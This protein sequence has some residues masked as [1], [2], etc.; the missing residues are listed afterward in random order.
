M[1]GGVQGKRLEH[2]G[3]DGRYNHRIRTVT[4]RAGYDTRNADIVRS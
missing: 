3:A 4:E 1:N 2:G